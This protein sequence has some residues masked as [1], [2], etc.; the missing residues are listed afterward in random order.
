MAVPKITA[1]KRTMIP[2][3]LPKNRTW[4]GLSG[5]SPVQYVRHVPGPYP[6]CIPPT[7]SPRFVANKELSHKDYF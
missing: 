5:M 4:A 2:W 3:M 6:N 1:K 7:P